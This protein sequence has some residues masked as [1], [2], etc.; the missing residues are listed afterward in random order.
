MAAIL[1]GD[2]LTLT[3]DVGDLWG[4]DAFNYADVFAAL[5]SYD[6]DADLTVILNSGGGVATEG[7]AIHSLL[8]QRSGRTDVRIDG[9]AASAASLIAMAG[10]TVTMSAGSTL[11]VHDPA[12]M[13]FGNSDAHT[14]TV[15][16]LEALATGYAAIYARKTGKTPEEC[17][18]V[19]K[20]ETW[21]TPDKAVADGFADAV[22]GNSAPAV[23]AFPYQ[24]YAK[25]PER[26]VALAKASNWRPSDDQER[27]SAA[28]SENKETPMTDKERADQLAAEL[29]ALK[30]QMSASKD[31]EKIAS[32]EA[33]LESHR[34]EKADRENADA[35]MKLESAKDHPALAKALAE[36]K[37]PVAAADAIMKA[38]PKAEASANDDRQPNGAGLGIGAGGMPKA[39][40]GQAAMLAN[41]NKLI[42][43][44]A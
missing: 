4:G 2:R 27:G 22:L 39:A 38:T 13:T 34:K 36:Q 5:A 11:M 12:G 15:E 29:E 9:I 33:E 24:I 14:K 1:D 7:A 35:I 37:T 20:A 10:E 42:G 23:A 25:A 28:S 30:A 44:G 26:F 31:A 16:A 43:K 21:F 41:M 32:M 8:S 40:A 17:R 19:M 18:A 3:G 6:D